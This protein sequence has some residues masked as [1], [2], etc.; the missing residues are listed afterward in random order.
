[1]AGDRIVATAKQTAYITD[2]PV[3]RKPTRPSPAQKMAGEGER[4]PAGRSPHPGDG[5]LNRASILSLQRTI[6]NHAVG[7]LLQTKLRVGPPGDRYEQEADRVAEHV[8]GSI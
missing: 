3:S 8:V 4:A 6:G 1:M 5:P 2:R 7:R